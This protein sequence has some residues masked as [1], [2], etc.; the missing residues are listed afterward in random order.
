MARGILGLALL[1][2]AFGSLTAPRA[3]LAASAELFFSEYIEGSSNNK[4]LEIYNGT[5][6]AIDLAAGG[7]SVQ[8]FFNGSTS[9]GL[10]INLTG[11]VASGDVYV[12]AQSTAAATI[13]AQADQTNGAGWFNGDDAVVLR[14]GTTVIDAFGQVGF[15]PGTEWGTGLASTADNTLRRK[16]DV[17]AGDTNGSDVFNPSTEWDGFAT[18]AFDGLGAHTASCSASAT[19]PSITTQPQSQ[20]VV[21]GQSA[22]L[23]VIASGTAPLSYQW[24]AGVSGD[25]GSPIDGASTS[26]YTTPA[27]TA[28][29]SYWVRVSNSLGSDDS[30]T[31]TITVAVACS[32]ADTAIGAVQGSGAATPVG[33]QTVTVQ[34]VVVGDYEGPSP[35][36]RGF[37]LQDTGD[38]DPATSDGIFVF[39]GDNLNRVSL[40]DVVQVTGVAGENQGQTQ[41]SSTTGIERCGT[42]GTVTPADVTLPFASATAAEVYEGMLVRLPQTLYVTEH[43][44]LGRFGQV[45]LSSGGRLAQPTNVEAP[46]AAANALQAQNNLNRI[47][48]DDASQVQNPDPILFARGGQPL[49]ASNTLRGGDTATDIVGVMTFTWAGNAASGNA[50]RVRPVSALG[51]SINFEP[52]NPRPSA[53]VVVEGGVKAATFNLLNYFNTFDGLPDNVDNCRNGVSGPL[54]DCRG[55]DTADEFARQWPKTVDAILALNADVIAVNEIEND[56]YGPDS[57]IQHLVDR[58]NEATAP[59]TFA[60]IDADAGTGQINALGTDAIKVGMIYR[61]A[62]VAPVGQTAALNT[63]A[64]VNGGDGAPRSRPALAQSFEEAASGARFTVVAN[65]FKSKGSACDNPDAGDGQGNCNLVRTRAAQELVN[66]LAGDPTGIAD[67]D[68]LIIGDL[69]SYAMEDPI[70]TIKNAGYINLIET[71][72]GPDA[73]SYVF[74]GQWGYLDHAL[75]SSSIAPQVAGIVEYH[76]NADEPSVLDYNT[77]FKTANLITTLYAVDQF[78]TS[79]HDPVVVG[80][81]LNV[82]PAPSAGGP[83][84]VAEGGSVTLSAEPGDTTYATELQYAW[85]LDD[86]GSFETV[87]KSVTFSAATID[88]PAT[89]TVRVQVTDDLGLT[90]VAST[91]VEVANANP[92]VTASF[93]SSSVACSVTST[94]SGTITD[95]GVADTFTAVV[96]W[97]DGSAPESV[98]VTN[99]AFSA[100]HT[101]ARA[102]SYTATVT[103]TDD[104][105]GSGSATASVAVNYTVVGGGLLQPINQNGSSVFRYGSTIPVKVRFQDCDG[106]FPAT[107]APRI[108]LTVLNNGAPA[109]EINQPVSTSGA[110][111]TGI[112]R[113]DASSQQYIYNLATRSLP[114]PTATYRITITVPATGQTVTGQFGLR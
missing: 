48:L 28:D 95:P 58:L 109:G 93:A 74:D 24:Y 22:T 17:C 70:T 49:S 55:A 88:G 102:G 89:V 67:P 73:Y 107:L 79:D 18:D 80:L 41:I 54:T 56:G 1:A 11:T 112:L 68:T 98:T 14:K 35:A 21:S 37:Y 75:A 62:K 77:D 72:V 108:T 110:D 90:G 60:F 43:F 61:P 44:Q 65:H 15:D 101:Y 31:A 99:R 8:M 19:A 9:A 45:V 51:G 66:W 86:D 25:T 104:D 69:N 6:S 30:A 50:Y 82:A 105:G 36:L 106:S 40:G 91:T 47:I 76:I 4:A 113:Y 87:G 52:A 63:V 2:S 83:Y 97:G 100:S 29:A 53:P 27:L 64:F 3:A 81:N 57:A 96:N 92:T 94:L 16:A 34:G 85:D 5:G 114:D 59:G 38:G 12:V 46:G 20:S 42:T 13:L 103:V 39:E 32:A 7:Y 111:T 84:G 78:R 10:T 33:G 23:S 26:S 71:L